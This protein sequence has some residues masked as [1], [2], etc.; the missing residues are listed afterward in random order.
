MLSGAYLRC[1]ALRGEAPVL[2]HE[3]TILDD[4]DTRFGE[5]AGN[6]CG[7]TVS[8]LLGRFASTAFLHAH[9]RK[10]MEQLEKW[11]ERIGKWALAFGYAVERLPGRVRL[12]TAAVLAA[13][14]LASLPFLLY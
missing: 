8:Y 6:V 14:A 4:L 5:G 11:F 13:S 3:A 1:S 2:D 12:V 9:F 10:G 7:V